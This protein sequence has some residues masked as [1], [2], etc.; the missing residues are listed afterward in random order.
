MAAV[1]QHLTAVDQR[2]I[3]VDQHLI[4]FEQH[5]EQHMIAFGQRMTAVEQN[6]VAMQQRIDSVE[7]TLMLAIVEGFRSLNI[8]CRDLDDDLAFNEVQ[9]RRL[10]RRVNRL[11][12]QDED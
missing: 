1:D 12:R 8:Y 3:A 9:V 10:N 7:G 4:T 6:Q 2:M 5:V 11:E